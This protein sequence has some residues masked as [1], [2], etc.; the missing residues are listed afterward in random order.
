VP[1]R[2]LGSWAVAGQP[3]AGLSAVNL[4]KK[5]LPF[6]LAAILNQRDGDYTLVSVVGSSRVSDF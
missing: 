6:L 4:T 5:A 2:E 1:L 3:E